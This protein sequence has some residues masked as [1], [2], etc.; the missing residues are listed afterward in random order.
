MLREIGE[1]RTHVAGAE[2]AVDADAERLGVADG[3]VERLERL[4]RQRAAALVGD[5]ERDHQRQA[6]LLLEEDVLDRHQRRLRVQRVEDGSSRRMSAPPSIRPRTCSWYDSRSVS[7]VSARNAGSLTSERSRA[8]G[9][10]GDRSGHPARTIGRLLRPRVA[11]RAREPR[12]LQVQLVGQVLER[13]VRLHHRR[14]AERVGLDDVGAGLEILAVDSLITSGRV[15]ISRS[16]F[17]C[18]S[19]G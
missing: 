13:I 12:P 17:P 6:D 19:F 7:N 9:S 3:N 8:S 5:R 14:A 1:V 16:L 15:R 2:R 18:R 4:P 11:R 10:S